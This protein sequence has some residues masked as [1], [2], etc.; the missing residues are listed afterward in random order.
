[1]QIGVALVQGTRPGVVARVLGNDAV[2]GVHGGGEM[3][4][5]SG[6]GGDVSDKGTD[7]SGWRVASVRRKGPQLRY[8]GK[9]C[10]DKQHK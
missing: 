7:D 3:R 10:D 6:E 2:A 9:A 5:V 4:D 8:A 1:M